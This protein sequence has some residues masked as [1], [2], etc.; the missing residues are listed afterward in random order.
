MSKEVFFSINDCNFSFGKKQLFKDL[1]LT[2]HRGD[3]IALVG[4][5][6]VGKTTLL[7]ILS[8]K[9]TLDSGEYWV[10]PKITS[11]Y[12]RQKEKRNEDISVYNFL[13]KFLKAPLESHNFE[14]DSICEKMKID[15]EQIVNKLSGGIQRRLNLA[16]I[17]IKKPKLLLLDEPTNHL[18]IESIK[19]L[20]DFLLNE[21]KGAFLVISHNRNFLKNV[22]NKVF[23]MDRG[24]I[25]VS[26]KGFSNFNE[27]SEEL[28]EQ[29]RR[30]IHNKEKFLVSEN[31]WLAK[32]VTA[33]RKRN[34][35]RKKNIYEFKSNLKKDRSEFLKAISKTKII[36]DEKSFDSPNLL[37]NFF[38]VKKKFIRN[39]KEK[40]ILN[41]F[42]FKLMRGEK[43]GILGKNGSGKST[44]LNLIVDKE[45]IDQGNI[46]IRKNVDLSFFDQSGKQFDDK[47]T[48]KENLIPSG[49]DFI[50]VGE[51]KIHICGYLKNFLFEPKLVDS[52]VGMLS[53]GERNRLLLA[54]ILADPKEIILLDEPTNDLDIETID[55]LID[56][57]NKF[58]GAAFIASHDIDFLKKTSDK[59]FFL[60]GKGNL[61]VSLNIPNFL[62]SPLNKTF[63]KKKDN[64]DKNEKKIKTSQ[65]L[66]TENNI[67]KVL[68]KIE[69]KEKMILELT[70]KLERKNFEFSSQ[71]DDY[72]KTVNKIKEYQDELNN[73][74]EKWFELE[75]ESMNS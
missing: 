31:E 63:T 71:D 11:G 42:S 28:I 13:Q 44:F 64:H 54:K 47:K 1:C 21:F 5:N 49:G 50:K 58:P 57:L 25:K 8:G 27:W 40:I 33:R 23:W 61:N 45:Q 74:E 60:D 6:G 4:K 22:T 35:R 41:N 2:I 46:K 43:I 65:T 68:I 73:L 51:K 34:V 24:I 69:K 30:E 75:E 32:G 10:N 3:R 15:K 52:N 17:I 14:I 18:D 48:I 55:L 62:E 38:N 7:K 9:N 53:G 29:E 59:F 36:F 16:S 66:N 56:F 70:K 19:W 20:E 67:K 12:L 72:I 37:I 26:P 39:K